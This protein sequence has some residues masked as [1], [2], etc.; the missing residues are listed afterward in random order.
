MGGKTPLIASPP[1]SPPVFPGV[2]ARPS[3]CSWSPPPRL[4][5]GPQHLHLQPFSSLS[6]GVHTPAESLAP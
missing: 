3:T 6:A 2:K 5:R 4:L 1:P